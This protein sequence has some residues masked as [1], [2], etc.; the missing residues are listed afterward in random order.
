MVVVISVWAHEQTWSD[1]IIL[2]RNYY[3][4]ITERLHFCQL[5]I[6]TGNWAS[7]F[8]VM[9]WSLCTA[10]FVGRGG[11]LSISPVVVKVMT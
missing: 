1:Y 6:G 2:Q 3:L 10:E 4:L 11:L 5:R 8:N 7:A 9:L